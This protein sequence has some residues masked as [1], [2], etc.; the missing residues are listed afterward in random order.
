MT[1]REHSL[2]G[3]LLGWLTAQ[4]HRLHAGLSLRKQWDK[5]DLDAVRADLLA[6]VRQIMAPAHVSLWL[7]ERRR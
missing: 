4:T 1:P 2:R 7:R 3:E 6:V 5:V